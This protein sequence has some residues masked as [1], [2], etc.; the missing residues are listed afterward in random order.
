[1]PNTTYPLG[2]FLDR[3]GRPGPFGGI[4]DEY[5]RAAAELCTAIESI[6][7]TTFREERESNDPDT[8]SLRMI[9]VHCINAAFGYSNMV[10]KERG[11]EPDKAVY[12]AA[13]HALVPSAF[14]EH[15]GRAIRHTAETV[16]PIW[17]IDLEATIASTFKARWGQ[18]YDVESIFEHG[19]VHLLRHR[20]QIE[21]W[22]AGN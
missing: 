12:L 21:R 19:I 9:C 8:T 18:T 1:M 22:I 10:R 7:E 2:D 15:I 11:L 5:A 13:D 17:D 14:R 16:E 3:P 4:L 20:R 6:D